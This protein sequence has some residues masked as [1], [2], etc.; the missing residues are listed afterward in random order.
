MKIL[1]ENICPIIIRIRKKNL[2]LNPG[3]KKWLPCMYLFARLLRWILPSYPTVTDL[4]F[5]LQSPA[6][7]HFAFDG[8]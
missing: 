8:R 4:D 2:S 3:A 1:V 6:T 7:L 5:W